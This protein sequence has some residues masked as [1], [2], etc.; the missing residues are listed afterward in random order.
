[1][2]NKTLCVPAVGVLMLTVA[3]SNAYGQYPIAWEDFNQT[4]Q[5]CDGQRCIEWGVRQTW[6]CQ[7]T[8]VPNPPPSLGCTLQPYCGSLPER[9]CVRSEKHC[10]QV[11][12]RLPD[13]DIINVTIEENAVDPA[14]VE[15]VL[16]TPPHIT[17][18]QRYNCARWYGGAMDDLDKRR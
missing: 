15:F 6:R 12:K 5:K 13:G 2:S 10:Y 4:E 14:I 11:P 8:C 17:W 18:L 7:N 16:N 1:M 3:A 9:Y